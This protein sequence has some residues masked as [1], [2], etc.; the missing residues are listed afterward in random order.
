MDDA[1]WLARVFGLLKTLALGIESRVMLFKLI[2]VVTHPAV[3]L[4]GRSSTISRTRPAVHRVFDARIQ[5][6][7][8]SHDKGAAGSPGNRVFPR[9]ARSGIAGGN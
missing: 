9:D 1:N 3:L 4:S 6:R 2:R 5:E 8:Y 7:R